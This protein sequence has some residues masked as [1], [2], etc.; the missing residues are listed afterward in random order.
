MPATRAIAALVLAAGL[1]GACK[2]GPDYEAPKT[3][4]APR[5]GDLGAKPEPA[6]GLPAPAPDDDREDPALLARWWA[7]FRDPELESLI[8]RALDNN[9]DLKVAV[10]RVREA[11]AQVAVAAGALIPEAD[12]SGGY[13]RSRGSKNVVLPLGS[14]LGGSGGSSGSGSG[15]AQGSAD[16][17]TRSVASDSSGTG[18]SAAA[19][20]FPP[21]GPA[22]PFGEGGLPGVTTNLYQAGFDAVWQID[23]FGGVRRQ[24][25]AADA[26]A[27]AAL[28]GARG[29]R[30]TLLAEVAT[31]YLQLR[32]TQERQAFARR[33]LETQRQTWKIS[34]DKFRA[35][36]GDE[37]QAAAQ[38]AQVQTTQATLPPLLALERTEEHALA[39]LVGADP[40]ALSGEL[41]PPK[42]LPD[43]PADLPVG[44]PSDLLRRRPDIRQAERSLA[45]ANAAVGIATAQLFPQFS[46]TGSLGIDSS[47]LKHLPEWSSRYYSIAP[48]IR[49]PILDW[50]RLRAA[51]TVE[52]EEQAQA[53][54]AY[55]SAVAQALKEVEDALVRYETE[56]SRQA[57]LAEAARQARRSR[58]VSAQIYGQGLADQLATLQAE[59]DLLQAEDSLEQSEAGLRLDLVTL[60]KALG[61]GWDPPDQGRLPSS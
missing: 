35:G 43:L 56:R 8:Q 15:K 2:V 31:T 54:L 47:D 46:I 55:E 30:V 58:D 32:S 23:V 34:D 20:G 53:R 61:G 10:S 37:A 49:W 42:R 11:R 48:G 41:S 38:A 18:G 29:V 44:V 9:R 52:D 21:G 25:E 45:A 6:P 60:Y 40:T 12:A 14:L 19:S 33:N 26:Q 24:V 22:S 27:A 28:E 1:L 50:T 7:V 13:N 16:L 17:P 57:L 51:I 59:R 3:R 5:F 36:L 39:F 4:L